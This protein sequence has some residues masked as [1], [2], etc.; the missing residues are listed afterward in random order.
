[1]KVSEEALCTPNAT[2]AWEYKT[3][4]ATL[5]AVASAYNAAVGN[6]EVTVT[7]TGFSGTC[8]ETEFSVYGRV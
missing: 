7:G 3:P 4:N 2:C 1:L 5:T 8:A 6:W